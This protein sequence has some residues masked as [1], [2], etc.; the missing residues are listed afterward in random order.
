MLDLDKKYLEKVK[1]I[2]GE[3][4]PG[5]E[6]RAF[7]SR[8]NGLA[9]KYSDLD[10]VLIAGKKIADRRIARLKDAFSESDLPFMVDVL[11][12]ND[13]SEDF[14][15]IIEKEWETVQYPEEMR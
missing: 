4:V 10:L 12:W 6:V 3:I 11:D 5:C 2:L 1:R 13:I 15:K 9:W 7:G 14:R 8:V